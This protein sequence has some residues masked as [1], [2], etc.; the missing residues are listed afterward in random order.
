MEHHHRG[1]RRQQRL[2]KHLARLHRGAVERA[3]RQHRGPQHAVPGV[4]HQQAELLD[5]PRTVLWHEEVRRVTRRGDL[6]AFG[7]PGRQHPAPDFERRQHLRGACLAQ[8]LHPQQVVAARPQQPVKPPER[9]EQ[10]VRQDRARSCP[11]DPLPITTAS[12]SSSPSAEA[13]S[14]PSFS[15]GRSSGQAKLVGGRLIIYTAN[16]VLQ[17]TG[18]A[19]APH[20]VGRSLTL[21]GSGKH[22]EPGGGARDLGRAETAL[23]AGMRGY[24]VTAGN[25]PLPCITTSAH[26]VRYSPSSSHSTRCMPPGADTST[27]RPAPPNTAPAT[28]A[29][30][31]PVPD[32]RVGPTPRSQIRM[33]MRPGASTTANSTFVP[34]GKN[35]WCSSS[36]PR[37]AHPLLAERSLQSHA[38]RVPDAQNDHAQ[39]LAVDVEIDHRGVGRVPHRGAEQRPALVASEQAQRF[40]PASVSTTTALSGWSDVMHVEQHGGQPAHAVARD[41]RVAAVGVQQLHRGAT[42]RAPVDDQAVGADPG[43]ALAHGARQ[44]RPVAAGRQV[45]PPRRRGNRCRRRGLW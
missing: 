2:A 14:R 16:V 6:Q 45:L 44:R 37:R 41:L 29:A 24:A 32:E 11:A 30:H 5:R 28:A 43:A 22:A 26:P 20:A 36:G 21:A 12:S 39:R 33:R 3:D 7:R 40:S 15:R 31:V 19:G 9:R 35:G 38:L 13:P 10:G 25:Q 42:R 34:S 8:P 1:R 23:H 4:E 27:S 18:E 17:E